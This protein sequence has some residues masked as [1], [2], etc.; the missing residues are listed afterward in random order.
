MQKESNDNAEGSKEAVTARIKIS[1]PEQSFAYILH[2]CNYI[3]GAVAFTLLMQN[4]PQYAEAIKK[5][6]DAS[7]FS[8]PT[9]IFYVCPVAFLVGII[10]KITYHS[11]S[12]T[13]KVIG[14]KKKWT[15]QQLAPK[16]RS[17]FVLEEIP[18]QESQNPET[19]PAEIIEMLEFIHDRKN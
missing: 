13:W 3:G 6:E 5:V 4:S 8:M 17:D 2:F 1:G 12:E 14:S 9:M 16:P 19:V 15:K 7:G 18:I 11:T 10:T